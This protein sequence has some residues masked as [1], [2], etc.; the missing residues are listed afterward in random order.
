MPKLSEFFTYDKEPYSRLREAARGV[1]GAYGAQNKW[2]DTMQEW[3]FIECGLKHTSDLIHGIAHRALVDL[4]EFSDILHERH[5]MTEYPATEELAEIFGD[6]SD[7][8]AAVCTVLEATGE[9]LKNFRDTAA[10][11]PTVDGL[12]LKTEDL[13]MKNSREYDVVLKLW[14]MWDQG[15]SASSFDNWAL[16]L[17]DGGVG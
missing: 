4:D 9:A 12:A 17:K 16:H 10:A 11:T 7:V 1:T 8:F 2:L 14:Q 15:V 3:L 6:P 13:M 5:L